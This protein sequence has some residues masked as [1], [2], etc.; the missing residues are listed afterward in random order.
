M[1]TDILMPALSPTMEQG[2]LAKWLK[3][4]GDKVRP[5]DVLAEIETDKATMEVEAIDEG[6]LAKILVSDGTDN[7]AVN[8][9]IAILAGEGE[10]VSAASSSKPAPAPSAQAAPV[11]DM[12]A[13]GLADRPA[14]AARENQDISVPAAPSVITNRTSHNAMAEIPEG[15]EMVSM[16]VREA[17]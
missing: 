6:V 17:L 13:E 4:E 11:P 5:G 15:T 3:K 7:V 10:S 16:T 8:T 2:K 12:Q 14:P 1:A 9:P